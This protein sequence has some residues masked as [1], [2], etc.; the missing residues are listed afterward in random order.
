MR[1]EEPPDQPERVRRLQYWQG[2]VAAYARPAPAT[3]SGFR[4][5][6]L[7]PQE[8]AATA[9]DLAAGKGRT[10]HNRGSEVD[11]AEGLGRA[12]LPGSQSF[13]RFGNKVLDEPGAEFAAILLAMPEQ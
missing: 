12:P 2:R 6:L 10:A 9:H 4:L 7:P 8:N 1:T 11:H 5:P 13:A 3:G